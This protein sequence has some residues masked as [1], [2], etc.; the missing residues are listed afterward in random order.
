MRCVLYT[1]SILINNINCSLNSP[2]RLKNYMAG[3]KD[4]IYTSNSLKISFLT[5]CFSFFHFFDR[6]D[7]SNLKFF[8]FF[9]F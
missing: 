8:I 1:V 6:I 4:K 2:E 5:V 9:G 7:L 3:V